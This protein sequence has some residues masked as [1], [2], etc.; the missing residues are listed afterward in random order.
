MILIK[1]KQIFFLGLEVTFYTAEPLVP[2][3]RLQK[4]SKCP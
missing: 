4:K 3:Q 2:D 1:L